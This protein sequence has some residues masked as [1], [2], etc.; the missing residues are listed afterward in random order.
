MN[1]L[2]EI[3]L[4]YFEPTGDPLCKET[5]ELLKEC[6]VKSPC[7]TKTLNFKRCMRVDIDPECISLRK[8]YA[9]CK[10]SSIDRSRDFRSEQR[11][12]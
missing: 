12:K 10:R 6:V 11:F 2:G 1:K 8:Q 9:R 4:K 7:F 5:R 3:W